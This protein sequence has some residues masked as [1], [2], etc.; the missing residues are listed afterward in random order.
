MA[1][2]PRQIV[3][4]LLETQNV[5]QNSLQNQRQVQT[6][7]ASLLLKKVR[8]PVKQN[9]GLYFRGFRDA[10]KIQH[11]FDFAYSRTP[12]P[13]CHEELSFAMSRRL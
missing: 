7:D 10:V 6:S 2:V 13:R 11:V 1:R 9:S 5:G 3:E 12:S 8:S 4:R